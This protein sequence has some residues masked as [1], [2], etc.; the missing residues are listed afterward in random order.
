MATMLCRCDSFKNLKMGRSSWIIWMGLKFTHKS[1][2]RKEAKDQGDRRRYEDGTLLT[3]KVEKGG[4]DP[5]DVGCLWKI[6]KS[7]ET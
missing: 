7:K 6:K 3:S 5:E 2:Y 1:L 4:H